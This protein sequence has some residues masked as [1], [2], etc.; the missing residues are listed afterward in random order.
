[1]LGV[2]KSAIGKSVTRL[3]QRLGVTL[4][5]RSPRRRVLTPDGETYLAQCGPALEELVLAG[6]MMQTKR[7]EIAG[8]LRIDAPA[9]WGRK[10]LMPL[11]TRLALDHPALRLSVTFTDRLIDPVAEQVD[12]AIRFG[13]TPDR[14]GL[15]ARRIGQQRTVI[16]AAPDYLAR[17]GPPQVPDDLRQHRCISGLPGEMPTAWRLRWPNGTTDRMGIEVAHE[18]GDGAAVVDAAVA[19]LGLVQMPHALLAEHLDS[20]ALI[21]VLQGFTGTL[22]PIYALWPETRYMPA[23]LRKALDML[24]AAGRDGRL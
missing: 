12:L 21:E 13:E 10:I 9:F 19:G 16:V 1:M 23:R 20:G 8:R 2:T 11:L 15:T 5:H 24:I 6:Q 4:L 7:A 17:H 3:E 14:A 18:L 22:V